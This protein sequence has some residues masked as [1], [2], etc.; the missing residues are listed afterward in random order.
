MDKLVPTHINSLPPIFRV[1]AKLTAT[2]EVIELDVPNG[3]KILIFSR[4]QA[5]ERMKASSIWQYHLKQHRDIVDEETWPL[6]YAY[7]GGDEDDLPLT[8]VI[9]DP[10]AE[11]LE[12]LNGF[13]PERDREL[14][15]FIEPTDESN[16][17]AGGDQAV[18]MSHNIQSLL[19][20]M[21]AYP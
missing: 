10:F 8:Q 14:F 3:S 11:T 4:V 18:E 19:R 17:E 16:N 9:K 5:C 6:A 1:S 20:S 7:G 21:G 12:Y 15:A 13:D 2:D